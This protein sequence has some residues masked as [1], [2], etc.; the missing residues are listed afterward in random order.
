VFAVGGDNAAVADH[1]LDLLVGQLVLLYH[2]F[3]DLPSNYARVILIDAYFLYYGR[4]V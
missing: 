3:E 2:C 4:F 1:Y